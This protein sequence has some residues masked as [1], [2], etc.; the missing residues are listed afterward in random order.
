MT[1]GQEEINRLRLE[2]ANM[3]ALK[4][5]AERHVAL[6]EGQLHEGQYADIE[7]LRQQSVEAC[8]ALQARTDELEELKKKLAEAEQL[9]A[10]EGARA[11]NQ[12]ADAQ[13]AFQAKADE[14]KKLSDKLAEAE[15]IAA[16]EGARANNQLADAQAT[17]QAKADELKKLSDKL[18]EAEQLAAEEGARADRTGMEASTLRGLNVD[19]S[20]VVQVLKTQ[21]TTVINAAPSAS[22]SSTRDDARAFMPWYKKGMVWA[23][24]GGIPL[25]IVLVIVIAKLISNMPDSVDAVTGEKSASAMVSEPVSEVKKQVVPALVAPSIQPTTPSRSGS[26]PYASLTACADDLVKRVGG[27]PSKFIRSRGIYWCQ[28]VGC[29]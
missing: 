10:E 3:E 6:L 18:A 12:L 7:R 20:A 4:Q 13:V 27:V 1:T 8:V 22:S 14:L 11:N 21:Q 15:R 24:A 29:Q 5:E 19:L 9:A 17:F 26:C 28:R 23:L 16:E 2:L 25:A